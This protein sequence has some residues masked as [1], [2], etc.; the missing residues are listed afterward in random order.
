MYLYLTLPYFDT[1]QDSTETKCGLLY[2]AMS[3][4]TSQILKF[5]DF[6]ETQKFK[7]LENKKLIFL[8]IKKIDSYTSRACSWQKTTIENNIKLQLMWW[9]GLRGLCS[10]RHM[11]KIHYIHYKTSIDLKFPVL[12]IYELLDLNLGFKF[13]LPLNSLDTKIHQYFR[14]RM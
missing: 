3:M 10:K 13:S 11:L 5:V 14:K 12:G 4:M 8:Q 9:W 1:T 2:D 6:T 7:Y